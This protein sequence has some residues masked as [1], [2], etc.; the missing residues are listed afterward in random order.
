MKLMDKFVAVAITAISLTVV[1]AI[2]GCSSGNKN[3]GT[4]VPVEDP[5]AVSE[6]EKVAI[7]TAYA[8]RVW[9][10]TD[11]DFY[12]SSVEWSFT[13]LRRSLCCIDA[14]GWDHCG[15]DLYGLPEDTNICDGLRVPG[16]A[17]W[18]VHDI[19]V[20]SDD[21]GILPD[22]DGILPFFRGCDGVSTN[23]A[24]NLSDAPAYSFWVEK[25]D[26]SNVDD[27]YYVDLI[28]FFWY[29]FNLGKQAYGQHYG[30]HIGDW[31]HV[32]IRLRWTENEQA[33]WSL[34]P[35]ELYA[36]AHSYGFNYHWNE[37]EEKVDGTHPAIFSA[38]GSHGSYNANNRLEGVYTYKWLGLDTASDHFNRGQPWDTW[39]RL[40][41]Y[42]Y[43]LQQGLGNSAWPM[44][45]MGS[46]TWPDWM[47]DEDEDGYYDP[48]YAYSGDAQCGPP[49]DPNCGP[50]YRWGTPRRECN[51][52]GYCILESGPTGPVEKNVWEP[53]PL[54]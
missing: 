4:P 22:A 13:Y 20:P 19:N 16:L 11:E 39:H 30:N 45:M 48:G 36:P 5:F 3:D 18:L 54:R 47:T 10:H 27:P 34:Q 42:D 24:C 50:I 6:Q 21:A 14:M 28:Y 37:V 15:N 26:A 51:N 52:A 8:P 25:T 38:L 9:M 31:E 32:S 43:G 12:P 17:Y 1:F 33:E 49:E 53:G 35:T 41:T 44:W 2:P 29:P 7:L 23:M 40:E 46:D